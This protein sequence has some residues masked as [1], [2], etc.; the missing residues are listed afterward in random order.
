MLQNKISYSYYFNNYCSGQKS[1]LSD[2]DFAVYEL[3]ARAFL[4]AICT[5]ELS[6]ENR[7]DVFACVCSVAEEMYIQAKHKNIKSENTDG[8]SVTFCDN[9][10]AQNSLY[11]IANLYL[12]HLGVVHAGVR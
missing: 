8:Y 1:V 6:E 12:G 11:R 3:R 10:N 4:K 7:D 9:K 5:G 2:N